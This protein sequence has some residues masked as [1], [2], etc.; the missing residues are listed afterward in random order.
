VNPEFLQLDLP[1][2]LAGPVA[3]AHVTVVPMDAERRLPDHTLILEDGLIRALGPAREV[4]TT[5]MRVIDGLGKYVMPGLA[6]MYTHYW[7]SSDCPLYL[8]HGITVVRTVGTPFQLAMER[9]AERGEFPS[10]RMIT[11]SPPIDGVGPNGRTDMPRGVAMTSP[12]QAEALVQRFVRAGYHQIKAFSL[13]L[14]ENLQALGRAAAGAGVRMTANCPN[15]M[16]F[17]EA[18]EAGAS[19]FDQLHNIARGHLRSDAP[20]PELWDRFDPVPG[21]RLDFAAIRRLAR[22]MAER[23]TWN[24]P[25][26]V[27]H[28]RDTLSP[29]EGMADP[30]LKYVSPSSIKD[31]EST[32]IRWARRARLDDVNRWRAIARERAIAFLQVV[33][34]FHEEGVPLLTGTDSLNPWN[35]QGAS[36]HE[37]LANFVAAGM[38]PFAALR[39]ATTEAA[40]FLGE[41]ESWGTVAPG[42]RADLVVTRS[43]PLRDVRAFRD[44]DAVFVNGYHLARADLDSLLAQ[45]AALAAAPPRLPA[46]NLLENTWV[47][48]IVGTETGR[49][50]WRHSRLADGGWL[51]EERHAAGV[52][53][54]HVER[55]NTR[56]VLDSDFNL[57][58]CA[59]TVDSFAGSEVGQITQS[60]PGKY[61]IR[62]KEVDGWESENTV[63]GDSM[64]PSERLTLTLWPL[65]FA[66]QL[67]QNAIVPALDVEGGSLVVRDLS[68]AMKD[69]G[70]WQLTV[71]RPTH[72][73]EQVY[74]LTHD[75]RFLGMQEMMPLLWLRELVPVS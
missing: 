62:I 53:R 15:A 43:N 31:W 4:D 65:L 60:A 16:T 47:E 32:L 1:Q 52:P 72:S 42:K 37:E 14:P 44:I 74:R 11:I 55:R 24:V 19:C 70:H 22:F 66:H 56:L 17:E 64:L 71:E 51:I 28:Q 54:R 6:D 21:T 13:L 30:Q 67:P 20:V 34:I 5:G 75:G 18:I 10:P 8:A 9:V 39:C 61:A 3:L 41:S 59:Y 58:S 40:R 2:R 68:L 12:G 57:Q 23:Q 26:L 50:A 45:R 48:R 38:S 25:T 27:F 46:V 29:A 33:S 63:A 73:T 7:D 35:V 36:L 49:I 69:K